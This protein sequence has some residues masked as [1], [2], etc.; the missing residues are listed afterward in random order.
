MDHHQIKKK[1]F[2]E[3]PDS[4]LQINVGNKLTPKGIGFPF[5]P[6]KLNSYKMKKNPS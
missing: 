5:E 6:V 3:I 1:K 2:L 4:L